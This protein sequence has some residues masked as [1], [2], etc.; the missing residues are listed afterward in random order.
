VRLTRDQ[1]EAITQSLVHALVR[2]GTI[3]T[4]EP[5]GVTDRLSA[6][7]LE[8]LAVEDKLNE[9]VREILG[10][11]NEEISRGDIN[12]Q[13]MFRKIKT[14]LARERKIIL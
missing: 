1:V 7:F 8:D 10:K 9:E 14:K 3:S 13:E 11:Y 12:Y 6:V 4:D 5:G 2:E